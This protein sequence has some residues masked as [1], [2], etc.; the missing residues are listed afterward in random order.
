MKIFCRFCE[1]EFHIDK[2]D[3]ED[4]AR[5]AFNHITESHPEKAI[6]MGRGLFKLMK[7]YYIFYKEGKNE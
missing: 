2:E 7:D 3:G 1:T 4:I 6:E 5:Q